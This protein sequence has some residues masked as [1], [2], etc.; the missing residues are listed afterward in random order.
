MG[1][2]PAR[3][4]CV[5]WDTQG[6]VQDL[7]TTKNLNLNKPLNPASKWEQTIL[8]HISHSSLTNAHCHNS[9]LKM[10]ECKE[11]CFD[12]S[13]SIHFGSLRGKWNAAIVEAV[14]HKGCQS[15][16]K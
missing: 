11:K 7:Q 6:E 9:S 15:T 10:S 5:R 1:L 4:V 12:F 3:C 8:S 2:K 16:D 13:P 14:N